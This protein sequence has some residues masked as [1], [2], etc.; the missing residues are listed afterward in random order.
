MSFLENVRRW[1]DGP[2]FQRNPTANNTPHV[3]GGDAIAV[4]IAQA[5]RTA[6]QRERFAPPG[7]TPQ[8][9]LVYVV[10][11]SRTAYKQL[12]GQKMRIVQD[13]LVSETARIASELTGRRADKEPFAVEILL[14]AAAPSDSMRV[15][16]FWEISTAEAKPTAKL[17]PLARA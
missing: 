3:Y 13:W 16:P 1:I 14:D 9:P 12:P 5:I 7:A 15:L 10:Y 6:M 17:A 4:A 8:V 2:Q 11:L